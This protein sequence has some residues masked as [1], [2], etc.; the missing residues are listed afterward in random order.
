[1]V[2]VSALEAGHQ[3]RERS[4]TAQPRGGHPTGDIPPPEA[5][6]GPIA[7]LMRR[8][9]RR[10]VQWLAAL[11]GLIGSLSVAT[12]ALGVGALPRNRPQDW[13]VTLPS[14]WTST[15]GDWTVLSVGFYTALALTALAWLVVGAG[16][17]A[18]RWRVRALWGLGGAWLLPWLA[19]PVAL[20]T[21]VYT[22][23]GQG[24]VAQSGLN[25]YTNGPGAVL[26]P[27]AIA[28]RMASIWLTR[29]SPYGPGFMG[30]DAA[31][32]PLSQQHII[33]A[34]IVMRLVEV[35]GLALAAACLPRVARAA[36]GRPATATW[37]GVISPLALG[38][39]VLSGHNDAWMV[40]LLVAAL[41]VATLGSRWAGPASVAIATL[42]A[43]VKVPAVVGVVV[44]ALA[45]AYRAPS[46]RA[47]AAR[48][49]ASALVAVAVAAA[50][51]AATGLGT[52]WMNPAAI[53]SPSAAAP[54]FTP[55]QAIAGT[56]S[57]LARA[58]GLGVGAESLMPGVQ[59]LAAIA[60]AAFAVLVLTR[61]Q[62]LGT[63][64][65]I[66]LILAAI[67]LATPVL[68]PWYFVWPI[69]L[70]G[71][72]TRGRSWPVLVLVGGA[73]LFLTEADGSA[74]VI[75]TPGMIVTTVIA[76]ALVGAAGR[77]SYRQLIKPHATAGAVG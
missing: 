30:L 44:L 47:A 46:R 34:V 71:A 1:M 60:A 43:M 4:L 58:A 17:H 75:G 31:I 54:Q 18:G 26:L 40:G 9:D 50:V 28:R 51:S 55:V 29:P 22:Y 63:T 56:L 72:A 6:L 74:M 5:D 15:A 14:G 19:G 68:W 76:L 62:R 12:T 49:G 16:V 61:Q 42:A 32:A 8:M 35:A 20:S 45:W 59:A 69:L 77:W 67:V 37:V 11:A 33:A 57:Y 7:K 41:A 70:L 48:L 21:D 66:G 52:A 24:L 73:A 65:T 2:R 27:I 53:S 36:G 64:R 10:W 39:C 38:A 23:L 13:W 25:P 3:R